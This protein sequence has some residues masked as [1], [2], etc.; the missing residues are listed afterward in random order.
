MT[1]AET[2]ALVERVA[3]AIFDKTEPLSGDAIGTVIHMSEH[4]FWD[5]RLPGNTDIDRQLAAVRIICKEA[6]NAALAAIDPAAI[7]RR[8]YE[9]AAG[10]ASEWRS[11]LRPGSVERMHEHEEAARDIATAIRALASNV[12]NAPPP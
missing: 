9:R 10:V 1:D 8:A 7:E 2:E 6:A 12:G 11:T 5:D 4:L 3:R